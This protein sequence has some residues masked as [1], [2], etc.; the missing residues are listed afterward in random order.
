MTP[1]LGASPLIDGHREL[2]GGL[3][4]VVGGWLGFLLIHFARRWM[5]PV[6]LIVPARR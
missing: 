6:P 5:A 1:G 4:A 2:H 3:G